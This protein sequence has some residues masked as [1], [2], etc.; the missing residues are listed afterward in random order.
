MFI[1]DGKNGSL[2]GWAL[3]TPEDRSGVSDFGGCGGVEGAAFGVAGTVAIVRIDDG[4]SCNVKICGEKRDIP[5][6][7]VGQSILVA[8][9]ETRCE[10][11]ESR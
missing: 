11:Y 2:Y 7:Q 5:R 3:L 6:R 4:D 9:V 1:D 8:L 10:G